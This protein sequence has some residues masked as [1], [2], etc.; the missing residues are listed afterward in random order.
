MN[1]NRIKSLKNNPSFA[2]DIIKLIEKEIGRSIN[3]TEENL[4][5]TAIK[6]FP[7]PRFHQHKIDDIMVIIKNAIIDEIATDHYEY[8]DIDTHEMLKQ[9]IDPDKHDDII[10]M[11]KKRTIK[12]VD[13][14]I[15]SVL[16]YKSI[17]TLVKKVNEPISSVNTIYLLLDTRYR[18]LENDGTKYFKWDHMNKLTIA[19]GTVNSFGEIR[20][21]I[22]MDVMPFKIPNVASAIN[23][24]NLITLSIDEFCS[25]SIIAHENRKFHFIGC[26]DTITNDWLTF[27]AKDYHKGEYKFNKP[28]TTLN[29]VTI[30]FGNPLAPITFDKD[31]LQGTI[32][33]GSPT[34]LTFDENHNL[35]NTSIVYVETFNTF[36]SRYDSGIISQFTND[37]GIIATRL[38]S[39]SISLPIDTTS[40]VSGLTGVINPPSMSLAGT[41]SATEN[42]MII[43]GTGTAFL[44]DFSNNDYIQIQNNLSN[45]IFQI[46]SI[47]S[48]TKLTLQSNYTSVSGTYAYRFTGLTIIGVGTA[49]KTELNSYDN[50]II[51]DN[52]NSPNFT[53]KKIISNTELLLNSPYTGLDGSGFTISK[54]NSISDV[55]GVYFGSKRIFMTMKLN[56]LSS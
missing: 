31:R 6:H 53:I 23:D 48:N 52:G 37:Q 33:Y 34:I 20:D 29:S 19:Q 54:D 32:T 50:V 21:I 36:N 43:I 16:G 45:P 3:R 35:N 2:I 42:S 51:N 18:T 8:N 40:I 44:N 12:P 30:K 26:I 41:I 17:S 15:E 13:I 25:Q 5:I 11:N 55:W 9:T 39:T 4:V 56:Y 47:Q 10:T 14:N 27:C 28:I 7:E 46:K 49:F 38:T 22:S 1:T 24:Y